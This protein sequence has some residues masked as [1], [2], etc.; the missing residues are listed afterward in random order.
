MISCNSWNFS[1]FLRQA[2]HGQPSEISR[3]LSAS[4]PGVAT[5]MRLWQIPL[6]NPNLLYLTPKITEE[7]MRGP[8]APAANQRHEVSGGL[9]CGSSLEWRLIDHT[10]GII[11]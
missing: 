3:Q 9:A 6:S 10:T 8:G 7:T 11:N 2:E 4:V 5:P 1:C